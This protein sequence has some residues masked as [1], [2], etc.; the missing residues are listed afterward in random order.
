[1]VVLR[2]W[3]ITIAKSLLLALLPVLLILTLSSS[4]GYHY[5]APYHVST[6]INFY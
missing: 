4:Q 5:I 1:M 6:H 3:L 2:Y